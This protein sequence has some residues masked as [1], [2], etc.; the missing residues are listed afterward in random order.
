MVV[1]FRHVAM[2]RR[3]APRPGAIARP[4]GASAAPAPRP[5]RRLGRPGAIARPRRLGRARPPPRR[6]G[7]ARGPK[8]PRLSRLPLQ[9]PLGPQ[10]LALNRA[11][12]VA[13]AVRDLD[14][15]QPGGVHP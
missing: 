7:R 9:P 15:G 2:A 5:P 4:P 3:S 12:A 6:L 1:N 11:Q 10:E 14:V 8:R 13:G